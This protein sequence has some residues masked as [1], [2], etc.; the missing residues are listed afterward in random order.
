MIRSYNLARGW[1]DDGTLP[2]SL[3]GEVLEELGL[4]EDG[5]VGEARGVDG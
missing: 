3:I 5:I 4:S 2:N 1:N